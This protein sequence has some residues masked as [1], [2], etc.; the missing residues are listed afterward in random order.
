MSLLALPLASCLMTTWAGAW[1][2]QQKHPKWTRALPALLAIPWLLAMAYYAHVVDVGWYFEWRSWRLTDVLIGAVGLPVGFYGSLWVT[3]SSTRTRHLLLLIMAS[4]L[5]VVAHAKP[6][7]RPLHLDAKD[8]RWRDDVCLQTTASTCGPC[9]TA[10]VLR[11]L[12]VDVTEHAL[13][14]DAY[15]DGGGTLNWLL[16]RALRDRGFDVRFSAPTSL[17]DVVAPAV[18]GVKLSGGYGHFLALMENDGGDVVIGE[19][20]RGRLQMTHAEFKQR[21][22]LQPFALHITPPP[23]AASHRREPRQTAPDA[24]G[25]GA[26]PA[27]ST[28]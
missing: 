20:L 4:M 3:T 24:G 22:R 15:S 27:P 2:A 14:R 17:D 16:A 6:L 10:T 23:R 25:L 7:L 19:P 13:A 5:V 11:A 1:L 18:I 21:H 9:A 28:P 8:Q 12:D 26:R